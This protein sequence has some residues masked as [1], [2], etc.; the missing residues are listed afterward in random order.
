ME[1]IEHPQIERGE[2]IDEDKKEEEKE[3]EKEY[4]EDSYDEADLAELTAH[5]AIITSIEEANR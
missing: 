4:S 3:A 1:E 2:L 5:E